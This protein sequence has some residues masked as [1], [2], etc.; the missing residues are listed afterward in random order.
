MHLTVTSFIFYFFLL[1][2]Y[3]VAVICIFDYEMKFQF[4]LRKHLKDEKYLQFLKNVLLFLIYTLWVGFL[5]ISVYNYI[6][7]YNCIY[8]HLSIFRERCRYKYSYRYV[9]EVLFWWLCKKIT[10]ILWISGTII[11]ILI[12]KE[13][14]IF[15][16]QSWKI[17]CCWDRRDSKAINGKS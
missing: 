10:K 13:N 8:I 5:Y 12:S 4:T 9:V 15:L 17:C 2:I 11:L 6:Y 16:Q 7:T 3:F 1:W 14:G